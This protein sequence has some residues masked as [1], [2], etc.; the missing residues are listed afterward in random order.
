MLLSQLILMT[1]KDKP[2]KMPEKFLDLMFKESSMN[3]PLLL[4]PTDLIKMM[5]NWLLS[6]I[7]VE[8]LLMYPS[9]KSLTESLKLNQLTE[10]PLVEEKILMLLFKDLFNKNSKTKVISILLK[11]KWLFKESEKPLKKLKLNYLQPLQ[12]KLIFHI[13]LLMLLDLN[14]WTCL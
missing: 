8:V 12:L 2:L 1:L 11:I 14:I 3:P 13:L 10:I 4:L 9:S 5:V 7:L 6:M